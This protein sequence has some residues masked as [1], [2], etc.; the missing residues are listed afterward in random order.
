MMKLFD[1]TGR[2]AL[3]T[4]GSRGIGRALAVGLA[5]AGADVVVVFKSA[6]DA[7]ESVRQ[8]IEG[9]GRACRVYQQDLA[10]VA[11]IAPLA[12]RIWS[13]A[14]PIDILVNN[15]GIA[16]I[17]RY[18]K[19]SPAHFE[20][21]LA[22]NLRAPF[23]LTKEIAQRMVEAS[24]AGRIINISSTNGFSAEADLTVYN[25]SKGGL[26]MLTK[27]FAIELGRH[28]ITVNSVAPGVIETEI[29]DD[30]K[31]DR[32]RQHLI[33][34]MPLGRIGVPGDCVGPVILL[35]SDAGAYITG[36]HIIVDG[37]IL[38]EQI[39]RMQFGAD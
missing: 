37:G 32:M 26:E 25:A 10:D 18:N 4:G 13:E 14:G 3:V 9:K 1:L 27:S 6:A 12:A 5:E 30:A 36:Q 11:A 15:A 38:C 8:E 22:V 39:P 20:Q 19:V 28:G 2:R 31:W 16:V 29:V 34:H 33:E 35:A 7:A 23:F 21:G 17:E 24:I